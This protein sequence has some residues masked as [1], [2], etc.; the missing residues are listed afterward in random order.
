M[1]YYVLFCGLLTQADRA[2]VA[3]CHRII[4]DSFSLHS[5]E[6]HS[7]SWFG[8]RGEQEGERAFLYKNNCNVETGNLTK[9]REF[10]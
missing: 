6:R 1:R 7:V 10:K 8:I 5:D 3:V 9:N 2:F 4:K